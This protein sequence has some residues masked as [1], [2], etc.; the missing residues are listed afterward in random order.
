MSRPRF[1]IRAFPIPLGFAFLLVA[2]A[3]TAA[4]P[5]PAAAT[6]IRLDQVP[7]FKRMQ[8]ER[9]REGAREYQDRVMRQRA[10]RQARPLRAGKGQRPRPIDDETLAGLGRPAARRP[11]LERLASTQSFPPNVRVNDPTGE[12]S[13]T[14]SEEHVCYWQGRYG[15]AS[16]N[17]GV[18]PNYQGWGVTTD[19][20]NT[21]LDGGT[22]PIASGGGN[23]RGDPV[24]ALDEK[25]GTFYAAGLYF[26][27]GTTTAIA[28]ARGRFTGGVFGWENVTV[29]RSLSQAT[30]FLDKEWIAADSTTGN[31]YLSYT[32]FTTTG[33]SIV[34][35]RSID[36][37]ATFGPMLTLNSAATQGYVQ[38]SRP[39]V[40]PAGEVY[41][42]WYEIGTIDADYYR[43]A[44]STDHGVSFGAP[45]QAGSAYSNYGT[46]APGFNRFGGIQF[47][48]IAVDR[49]DASTRGRVYVTWPEAVDYYPDNLGTLPA[50]LEVEPNNSAATA[51]AFTPGALL[52]GAYGSTSDADWWSFS[53]TAGRTYVFYCDSSHTSLFSMQVYCTDQITSLALSGDNSPSDVGTSNV[54]GLIVWTAPTTA[55]YYLRLAFISGAPSAP[56]GY[57][58][59]TGI[60]V[61]N[62]NDHA[63]DARDAAIASS[64]D[65]TAFGAATRPNDDPVGFDDWLPEVAVAR[66]GMVYASWFD[67]RDLQAD[68]GG[69]SN[70]YLTRSTD[71]GASWAA[72]LRQTDQ[73]SQWT[74]VSS[75]LAPNEGDYM[76]MYGGDLL[77]V[78]WADGRSGDPNVYTTSLDPGYAVTCARDTSANPGD[79][80]AF[81]FLVFDRN[82]QFGNG[83]QATVSDARG[84]FAAAPPTNV[85]IAAGQQGPAP[86]SLTV[87]DTAAAGIN[88]LTFVWRLSDGA[89]PETCTVAL[90]VNAVAAVGDPGGIGFGLRGLDP[91]P[92]FGSVAIRFALPTAGPASL[93]LLDLAGRRVLTRDVGT[94]GA[95]MHTLVLRGELARLPA[96]VYAVRLRQ[97]DRVQVRK[98]T[99]VR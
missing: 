60:H 72:N 11:S 80:I 56:R 83:Y 74:F 18:G 61:A 6:P 93:E 36:Q 40:G 9:L 37:G 25:T 48:G 46:G 24:I 38:G 26:P 17:D 35:Q 29:V 66:D 92:A 78:V 64:A 86:V 5:V 20:G 47:A 77:G 63:R 87:P 58:V 71:G 70:I 84:W 28:V 27:T 50:R 59:Y 30:D 2:L 52:R 13:I 88:P 96:G 33:D 32:H 10:A 14:Q 44:K 8:A 15:L 54:S 68:C 41:V 21:W 31:L 73:R 3:V 79:V 39:A 94:L 23:W 34:F 82:A 69:S 7:G 98:L 45:V 57:R 42:E 91:N 75:N 53:A 81:P 4:R 67:W 90:T 62:A 19:G 89:L 85:G 51:T 76:G 12:G 22:L 43:V 95:G 55:T 97:Q 1:R 99:L 16:W 49:S 65:G